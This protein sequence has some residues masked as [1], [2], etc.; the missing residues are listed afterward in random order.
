[1]RKNT[2]IF[3]SILIIGGLAGCAKSASTTTTTS[4]SYT[5]MSVMNL[6]PYSPSAQVF[7]NN[8]Q[9]TSV[10]NP[11]NWS[12]SYAHITPAIYDVKFKVNGQD[13]LL[14]EI[15]AASYDS[16]HYYTL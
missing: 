5:Y 1:M 3:I 11:G 9:A 13:S 15:P 7:L 16:T 6:A 4:K 2:H 12:S 8:V 14:A 10:I